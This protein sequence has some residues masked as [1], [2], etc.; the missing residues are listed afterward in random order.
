ME[1][2]RIKWPKNAILFDSDG[3]MEPEDDDFLPDCDGIVLKSS[4]GAVL[5][6]P[7]FVLWWVFSCFVLF[8]FVFGC[9]F[10]G[11]E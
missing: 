1:I 9:F 11:G 5:N 7:V 6:E 8:V 3:D 2:W 4:D 10:L